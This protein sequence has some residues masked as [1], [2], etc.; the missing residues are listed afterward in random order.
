M[1]VRAPSARVNLPDF[2]SPALPPDPFE[3]DPPAPPAPAVTL[4]VT[5]VASS[6]ISTVSILSLPLAFPAK[7][8]IIL[9]ADLVVSLTP[10]VTADPSIYH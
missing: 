1:S 7:F 2:P 4:I 5:L 10:S 9:F 6:G 8:F 3:S